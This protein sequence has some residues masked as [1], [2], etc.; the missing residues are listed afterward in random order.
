[1]YGLFDRVG[2]LPLAQRVQHHAAA[3]EV[4]RGYDVLP[5]YLGAPAPMGSNMDSLGIDVAAAAM[6]GRPIWRPGSDDVAEEILVT[7]TS[8]V[9]GCLTNHMVQASTGCSPA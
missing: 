4:A 7:I 8:L 5:V 6:P 9:L 2:R 1:V 3:A